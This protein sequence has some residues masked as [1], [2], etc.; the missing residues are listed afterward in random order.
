MAIDI[1]NHQIGIALAYHRQ[2]TLPNEALFRRNGNDST[3]E[4]SNDENSNKEYA[5]TTSL[6]ALPPI[7]YMSNDPYHS[8]YAFLHHHG[9][10]DDRVLRGIDR[11]QRTVEVADQ[12]AQ[13][14][15]DRKVRGI[16]VRWPGDLASTVSGSTSSRAHEE[17]MSAQREE[18]H[19]LFQFDDNRYINHGFGTRNTKSEG[20][21]GYMRGR[22]LYLLDKCCT[23][24]GH[25]ERHVQSEPLLVEGSRP[26]AL[27]D[28]SRSEQNWITDQ[29][30]RNNKRT[31]RQIARPLIPKPC[32]K[33]GNSMSEMD[34]WGRAAIFGNQRFTHLQMHGKFYYSS[35]Q[36]YTG[37]CVS[38]QFGIE[39][40]DA[41]GGGTSA[42]QVR[43]ENFDS[44]HDSESR[45]MG[46][47]EGS[48]SA[49]HALY[50]FAVEHLH[51]R[52]TL[53]LWASRT[54]A[55]ST[56]EQMFDDEMLGERRI[57]AMDQRAH[58]AKENSVN[59]MDHASSLFA[60]SSKQRIVTDIRNGDTSINKVRNN[61]S[62]KSAVQVGT[63]KKPNRLASLVQMPKRKRR[64]RK[65][66]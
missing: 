40:A 47:F 10:T 5:A 57:T 8:S 50:D 31:P 36:N 63:N 56:R 43:S 32:D 58:D 6:T 64:S 27:W 15:H 52:I 23:S 46:D 9:P 20:S 21:Q 1:T 17:S 37:Y 53:P 35:K 24:H 48:L 66:V 45:R 42:S 39:N 60:S 29:Q 16:L 55:A 2:Q 28:T 38:N 30:Q 33:Y 65:S 4:S 19:L 13:I 7:P 44:L 34:P 62:S 59:E 12:L 25:D 22:I 14:A 51:G 54:S 18:G 3:I 26:F 61:S 41:G 49:M 11:V